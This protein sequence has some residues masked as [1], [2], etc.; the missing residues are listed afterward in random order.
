MTAM[1]PARSAI[2]ASGLRKAYGDNVV[3]DGGPHRDRRQR[4]PRG[5]LVRRAGGGRLRL[6][7]LGVPPSPHGLAG[8]R[9]RV[10]PT[11]WPES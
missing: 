8:R 2:V 10:A 6:G 4:R 11:P 5:R 3:L 1:A 7:A 9:A